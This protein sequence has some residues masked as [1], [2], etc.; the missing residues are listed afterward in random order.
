MK[1]T[2]CINAIGKNNKLNEKQEK[3]TKTFETISLP[4]EL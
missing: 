1:P 4:L 3:C 2:N